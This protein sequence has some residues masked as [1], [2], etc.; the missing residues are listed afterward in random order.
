MG[1]CAIKAFRSS[2]VCS[3]LSRPRGVTR[4][5]WELSLNS[6]GGSGGN[7]SSSRTKARLMDGPLGPATQ[8][9]RRRIVSPGASGTFEDRQPFFAERHHALGKILG[10]ASERLKLGFQFQLLFIAVVQTVP[11]GAAN[12]RQSRGRPLRQFGCERF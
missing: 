7:W 10:L 1:D 6:G 5:G 8:R 4:L 12:E 2:I 11:I 3:I 9:I